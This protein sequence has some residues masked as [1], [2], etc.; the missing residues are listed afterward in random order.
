MTEK[1]QRKY[2]LLRRRQIVPSIVVLVLYVILAG[3]SIT[4]FYDIFTQYF[5]ESKVALTYGNA[6]YLAN[7]ARDKAHAG[8][9]W[10]DIAQELCI[11]S[12]S[13]DS[14]A[15]FAND[16]AK[17][18]GWGKETY[19]LE[20]QTSLSLGNE[21]ITIVHD[22]GDTDL[23]YSEEDGFHLPLFS[24]LE[25]LRSNDSS[26]LDE[27]FVI[28]YWLSVPVTSDGITLLARSELFV[29]RLELS[30]TMLIIIMLVVLVLI[31]SVLLVINIINTIHMQRNMKRLFYTDPLTGGN[32]RYYIEEYA[33]HLFK[34]KN[35]LTMTVAVLSLKKFRSYCA[36]HG[37][38][39]GEKF[40]EEIHEALCAE[41]SRGEMC[42]RINDADFCVVMKCSSRE[43]ALKR[44]KRVI[45]TVSEKR[46]S[47]S[48]HWSVGF[49]MTGEN[50]LSGKTC[51]LT[52]MINNASSAC[53]SASEEENLPNCSWLAAE[54]FDQKLLDKQRWE[55][56]VE[57]NM[58]HALENNE[59]EVYLQPK[60]CPTDEKL[61][62]AEALI[63]WN[64]P[65]FGFV[66]PGRFIPIF[67]KNGFILKIDDYMIS[68]VAKLQAQWLSEG[69]PVVPVSVNVS[70]A[71]FANPDLAEHISLLVDKYD[72]PHEYIEIELTESA[73]FDDKDALLNT[74]KA[75]KK[76]GFD[77]SM[78]DF[79]SGYSSLNSLKDL[80]LDV[81]KLDAEFFRGKADGRGRVVV[82][83]AIKLAKSLEMRIVAEGVEKREQVDFLAENGCDMI[84]G[85]YFAKPMPV[86]EF[87]QK[88]YHAEESI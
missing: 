7:A 40:L 47:G 44:I 34:G 76:S 36:C 64:S 30:Y 67:E 17:L 14:A 62:G 51:D 58:E 3:F 6:V 22:S 9:E 37:T 55:H 61:S 57:E 60:F 35:A 1:R 52:Q 85:Y 65:E 24:L 38:A 50:E 66:S 53:N 19:N 75:L 25:E 18:A 74:V 46:G 16:N 32:N 59:F 28:H 26:T 29:S 23:I 21:R 73:F 15:F 42:G 72:V 88:H 70:R 10:G 56:S 86:R 39:A 5:F 20:K 11:G 45:Q 87:D 4:L 81:L 63:R 2:K 82:S 31:P 48:L 12:M 80:P 49:Y 77:I 8:E 13:V 84:Q 54:Y 83:E 27:T 69:K 78:D 68:S 41:I 79:G 71:H 43:E 33:S